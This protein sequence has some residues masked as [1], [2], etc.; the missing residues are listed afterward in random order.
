VRVIIIPNKDIK[1]LAKVWKE[2]R[3][4]SIKHIGS[5]D[6]I[7]RFEKLGV[8]VKKG[9]FEYVVDRSRYLEIE[10]SL[11]EPPKQLKQTNL[12]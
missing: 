3:F 4:R 1:F 12:L 8:F 6:I 2:G 5:G 11:P 9:T 10:R 7:E